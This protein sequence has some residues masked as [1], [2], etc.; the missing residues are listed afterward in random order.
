MKK[1][2]SLGMGP[3]VSFAPVRDLVTEVNSCHTMRCPGTEDCTRFF[4]AMLVVGD[5]GEREG[6]F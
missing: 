2:G 1:A 6:D 3:V 4:P 5:E